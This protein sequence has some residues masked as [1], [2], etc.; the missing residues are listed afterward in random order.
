[1]EGITLALLCLILG[2]TPVLAQHPNA[3]TPDPVDYQSPATISTEQNAMP[4]AG[5]DQFYDYIQESLTYPEKAEKKRIGGL[6]WVEIT[7]GP[8]GSLLAAQAV[9]GIGAG[10][11][12]EA[13][14]LVL[15]GPDWQPAYSN[16]MPVK[17]SLVIPIRFKPEPTAREK[18]RHMKRMQ[19]IMEKCP[20]FN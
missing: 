5:M 11:D 17:Q 10:C 14:R 15:E 4:I 7:V 1:L 12:R 2:L 9:E 3:Y 16:S 18:R 20:P 8:D 6:V 13:E 19:E